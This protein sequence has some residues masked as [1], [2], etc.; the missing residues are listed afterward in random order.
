MANC[1]NGKCEYNNEM[2][3]VARNK[4]T[5]DEIR[6]AQLWAEIELPNL[7]RGEKQ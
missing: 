4:R 3:R 1:E 6:Y 5:K 2:N 7:L